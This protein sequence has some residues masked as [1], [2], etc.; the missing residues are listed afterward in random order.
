M[1]QH[2]QITERIASMDA[3]SAK[4]AAI[5]AKE[6]ASL[7]ELCAGLGHKFGKPGLTIVIEH[8]PREVRSGLRHECSVCGFEEWIE[9]PSVQSTG[10]IVSVHNAPAGTQIERCKN[11][12][13]GVDTIVKLKEQIKTEMEK[14]INNGGGLTKAISGRLG[15]KSGGLIL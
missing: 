5:H 14:D 10:C 7:Q 1:I 9:Q 3:E 8:D 13:G 6:L 2:E 11:D 12:S 15:P 4:A